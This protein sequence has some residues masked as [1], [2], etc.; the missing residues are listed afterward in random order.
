[1]KLKQPNIKVNALLNTIKTICSVIFPLITFPYISRVLKPDNVG[2]VN[3][4]ASFVSYF[5]LLA[6]LGI[7]THA[8]RECSAK[9]E[10]KEALSKTASQIYSIN[11]CTTVIAYVLMAITLLFFRKFD[12]YRTLII[13][14]ST[15]I[16]FTTIGCDWLNTAM[17]DFT[18]ITIRTISFQV[19]SIILMFAFIHSEEDYVFYAVISVI[20]SSGANITNFFYRRKY[21][22]VRFTKDINW[23]YHFKPI[24]LLFVMILAQTIFSNA[25]ITMLGF[26]KSDAEVGIY[27]TALKIENIVAQVV[28]SLVWVVMP[29][30]SAYFAENEFDKINYSLKEVFGVLVL[31]G[32][33]CIAGV[34][35]LSEEIVLLVGGEEY[36]SSALPLIILF[37]A[38]GFSL[39]GGSF[40]GNMVLLPSKKEG[41]YMFICCTATV[42]NLI[43]NYFLIPI[44]GAVAA[45]G[46]T[47]FCSM[48]MMLLMVV[49]RDRRIKLDY[50]WKS[51]LSPF[52]GSVLIVAF[53]KA[54]TWLFDSLYL[55]IGI[56]ILGSGIIYLIV[57]IVFKNELFFEYSKKIIGKITRKKD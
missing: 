43:L 53:C 37:I 7:A 50:I 6:S 48:L 34:I 21:C 9:R 5:A 33:P 16:L 1:M 4:G 35:G 47:A 55:K 29:R 36:I 3:F 23:Q 2:K 11:I 51:M 15:A 42:V 25:D 31:F 18:F 10:N 26:M 57:S 45:A 24:A 56:S 12:A 54:V 14:Q 41:Q 39:L 46:T 13:I 27:S 17:E 30:L 38:F 8:I 19:I 52:I 49:L 44:W 32:F 40:L 22:K 20:S 28:T